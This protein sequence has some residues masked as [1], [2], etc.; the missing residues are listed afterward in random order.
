MLKKRIQ[1]CRRGIEI[2]DRG[3]MTFGRLGRKDNHKENKNGT[4]RR[5]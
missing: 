3:R 2:Q 1:L 5:R 4:P